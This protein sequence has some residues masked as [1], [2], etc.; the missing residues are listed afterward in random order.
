MTNNVTFTRYADAAM[1][2]YE[3]TDQITD[4]DSSF[5]IS[6]L[7]FVDT[8][9][10]CF[11]RREPGEV[12]SG[13]WHDRCV[14][15]IDKLNTTNTT[16]KTNNCVTKQFQIYDNTETTA[17]AQNI[18]SQHNGKENPSTCSNGFKQAD[19]WNEKKL[20]GQLERDLKGQKMYINEKEL[21][22]DA[23]DDLFKETNENYQSNK[24]QWLTF[25][26]N[27]TQD[28]FIQAKAPLCNDL[29]NEILFFANDNNTNNAQNLLPQT[30]RGTYSN[31]DNWT[32]LGTTTLSISTMDSN[33][34]MAMCLKDVQLQIKAC[35]DG[36]VTT[37]YTTT[38]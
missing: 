38:S 37:Q 26:A 21:T 12:L 22:K 31:G 6:F 29:S 13:F 25:L 19:G 36:K 20:K 18:L 4:C 17:K 14:S 32:V 3:A 8:V 33:G 5:V 24:E 2:Y 23:L 15:V 10:S 28:H 1:A 11:G 35:S 9:R 30:V 34:L 16:I 27:L 7:K